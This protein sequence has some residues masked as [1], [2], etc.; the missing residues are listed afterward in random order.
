MFS[1]SSLDT[2]LSSSSYTSI[3]IPSNRFS[4]LVFTIVLLLDTVAGRLIFNGILYV[5]SV[6]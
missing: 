3:D 2:I 6:P 5:S 1:N 4:K